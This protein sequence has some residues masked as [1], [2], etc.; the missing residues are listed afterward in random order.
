LR[1]QYG[2]AASTNGVLVAEVKPGSAAADSGIAVG[3][4]II[5]VDQ[6]EVVTP[7]AA[8]AQV[9]ALVKAGKGSVLVFV[10]RR[11]DRRFIALKLDKAK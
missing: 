10:S 8:K 1:D 9:D 3:D 2:V 11:D 7:E 5:E 4:V 6:K